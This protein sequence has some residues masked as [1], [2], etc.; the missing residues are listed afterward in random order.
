MAPL[1]VNITENAASAALTAGRASAP[2]Q[3]HV[4]RSGKS[5]K[6]QVAQPPTTQARQPAAKVNNPSVNMQSHTRIR[7]DETG[8]K[9]VVQIL[10]ENKQVIR[11]YPP[12][13]L[14]KIASRFRRL[15]GL[16]FDER[17]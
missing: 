7:M 11:Q 8:R 16:L 9:P 12:E 17:R 1:S 14:L 13:E 10:D 6:E 4:E 5:D 2:K 3:Q 15:Q